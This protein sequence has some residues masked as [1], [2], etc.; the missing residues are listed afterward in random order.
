MRIGVVTTSFP[1]GPADPAGSFVGRHVDALRELGHEVDVIAAGE[2][3]GRDGDPPV[4]RVV[5]RSGELFYAGGAPEALERGRVATAWNAASF[6]ARFTAAVVLRARQRRWDTV[7]AHWLAPSAVAAAL[8]GLP[9]TAIAHGGDVHALRRAGLLGGVMRL[10]HAARSRLVFV[11]EALRSHARHAAPRLGPWLDEALVQ[12]MGLDVARFAAISERA[13]SRTIA[14]IARL[15]PIK[16]VDV[17]I[18][19]MRELGPDAQLVIAG[20]GPLRDVLAQQI[21]A[22]PVASRISLLGELEPDARDRL[23][24]RAD[25]VVVPSRTLASG[26]EEG[27]PMVALEALAAGRPVVASRVGGL[28][29]LAPHVALVAPD[30]PAA[31]ARATARALDEPADA[32]SLRSRVSHLAWSEVAQRMLQGSAVPR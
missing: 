10:L 30:D 14:V 17:A 2:R 24:A 9:V 19:A 26:R 4:L 28:V 5:D 11:S 3:G 13:G 21:A 32:R 22:S 8:T 20:G 23:L 15:V 31:L 29:E 27:M 1:R 12:P 7:V 25:V 6:T 18:D 16:G